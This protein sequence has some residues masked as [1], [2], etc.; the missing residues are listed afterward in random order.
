MGWLWR[1]WLIPAAAAV[2]HPAMAADPVTL[3]AAG[4]LKA[5]LTDVASAYEEAYGTP[6]EAEFA[7]SA[8]CASGSK[9]AS[10]SMCSPRPTWRIRPRS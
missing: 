1:I 9:A 8:C 6:V 3:Y 10:R 5:A 7:A 4:N 2:W